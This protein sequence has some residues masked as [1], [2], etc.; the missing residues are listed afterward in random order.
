MINKIHTL[1][2]AFFKKTKGMKPEFIYLGYKEF[3]KIELI[4]GLFCPVNHIGK[5]TKNS[6]FGMEPVLVNRDTFMEVG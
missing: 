3:K 4:D 5:I 6:I 1:M 2:N